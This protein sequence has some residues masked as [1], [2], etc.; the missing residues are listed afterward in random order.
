M[1]KGSYDRYTPFELNPDA[2]FLV[3][4]I[5][6]PV[7]LVQASCN[8]YK[9]DR[10]LKG[11]DLGK[12]KDEVLLSFKPE[13]E[14]VILTIIKL[15]KRFLKKR[16]QKILL[17]LHKKIWTQFMGKCLLIILKQIQ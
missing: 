7:G 16:Q 5:G 10:E 8:P 14:K 6:A 9:E 12:I 4:G 13:L 2:D 11:V 1:K 15:L 3:T 17:G